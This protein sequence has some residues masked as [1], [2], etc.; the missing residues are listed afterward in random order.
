MVSDVA[1]EKFAEELTD[2]ID[3]LRIEHLDVTL[4]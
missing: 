3:G 1:D 2:L 4:D